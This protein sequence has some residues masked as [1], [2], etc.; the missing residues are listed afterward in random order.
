MMGFKLK[1][2]NVELGGVHDLLFDGRYWTVRYLV[3]KTGPWLTSRR[4]LISPHAQ[5][6][7]HLREERVHV[8]LTQQQILD[9]PALQSGQAVTRSFEAEFHTYY[10]WPVYWHGPYMWGSHPMIARGTWKRETPCP[11]KDEPD[12]LHLLSSETLRGYN[13][14]T[15]DGAIGSV[16]DFM[17]D[18]SN[19]S[20]RY[21]VIDTHNGLSG[22][23]IMISPQWI[24]RVSGDSR[25]L[26][27]NLTRDAIFNF[28]EYRAQNQEAEDGWYNEGGGVSTVC[29]DDGVDNVAE[30]QHFAVHRSSTLIRVPSPFSHMD[31]T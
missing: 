9:G 8:N 22:R 29:N 10:G 27:V 1:S 17:V 12:D 11:P 31:M 24:Q 7:V 23:K 16:A 14:E 2:L 25:T 30:I 5:L 19:W 4:V 26:F 20:I 13:I 3:A 6:R 21:L 15:A 18:D 28:P